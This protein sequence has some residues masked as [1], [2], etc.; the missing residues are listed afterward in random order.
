MKTI[1][2]ILAVGVAAAVV[3]LAAARADQRAALADA[4]GAHVVR[5]ALEGG[6]R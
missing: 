4:D 2:V 1:N 6:E 3:A 5:V